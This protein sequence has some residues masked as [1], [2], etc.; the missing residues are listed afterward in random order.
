MAPKRFLCNFCQGKYYSEWLVKP[1]TLDSK[2]FKC[3]TNA[4]LQHLDQVIAGFRKEIDELK[5]E[6]LMLKMN[7]NEAQTTNSPLDSDKFIAVKNKRI[8]NKRDREAYC[9][10]VSNRFSMFSDDGGKDDVD[11]KVSIMSPVI[12]SQGYK[13][14]ISEF[15][16]ETEVISDSIMRG[17]GATFAKK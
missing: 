10:H 12:D 16:S 17:L 6:N 4:K 8:G 11:E 7:I 2:C 3:I 15:E 13:D 14:Q 9:T 5:T 1:D